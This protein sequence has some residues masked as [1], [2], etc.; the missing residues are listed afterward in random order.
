MKALT[1]E[2]M[3]WLDLQ[4]SKQQKQPI[5]HHIIIITFWYCDASFV[6]DAVTSSGYS[7]CILYKISLQCSMKRM[8]TGER[9]G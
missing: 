6:T 3:D 9:V 8:R 7:A 1:R 2:L 4:I 5:A